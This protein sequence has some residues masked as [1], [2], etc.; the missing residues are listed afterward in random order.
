MTWRLLNIAERQLTF[1]WA[2]LALGAIALRPLWSWLA[3]YLRPCLLRT[4]TGVPC[5][6][7]GATRG[8]L[9]LFEGRILDAL[10]LNPLATVVLASF[11]VG[12]LVAPLW[13][14][15]RGTAPAL[16]SPLPGWSRLG[17]VVVV[18]ANWAWVIVHA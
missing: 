1:V 8:T 6:T 9:A 17:L 12:G 10:L 18:A 7:C 16:P 5:P 15:F 13:A 11:V 2:G 14:W 3:P 4:A